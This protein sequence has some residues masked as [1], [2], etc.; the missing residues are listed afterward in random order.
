MDLVLVSEYGNV[1]ITLGTGSGTFQPGQALNVGTFLSS[2]AVGDF[3]GDGAVDVAVS[4]GL[5]NTV[6]VFLDISSLTSAGDAPQGGHIEHRLRH[7]TTGASDEFKRQSSEQCGGG[8]CTVTMAVA[9]SAPSGVTNQ[10]TVSWS[11]EQTTANDATTIV[12]FPG[13]VTGGSATA[14]DIQQSI[15]EAL[16]TSPPAH[17]LNHDGALTIADVQIVLDAALSAVCLG[18]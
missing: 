9:A 16:G 11:G 4:D 2:V 10:V 1:T 14:V 7:R 15:N 18:Q 8:F 12:S 6:A 13:D 5:D 17:D 3:N